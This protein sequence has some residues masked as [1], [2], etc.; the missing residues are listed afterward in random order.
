MVLVGLHDTIA[1]LANEPLLKIS[2][3]QATGLAEALGKVMDYYVPKLTMNDGQA[4]LLGLG[5]ACAAVY[6]P[7]AVMIVKKRKARATNVVPIN[8]TQTL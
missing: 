7:K 8:A 4:A 1:D 2:P 5:I 6:G 3:A